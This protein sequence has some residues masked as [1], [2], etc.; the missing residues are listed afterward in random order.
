MKIPVASLDEGENSI[1]ADA[2]AE[3]LGFGDD[4][5]ARG[6][7]HIELSLYRQGKEVQVRGRANG[8]LAEECGRCLGPVDLAISAQFMV[9]ADEARRV[10][11]E[12]A[13]EDDPE[14]FFIRYHRGTIELAP[15]IREAILLERPLRVLCMPEC[16]GLCP[17]CGV[18]LNLEPC[19]CGSDPTRGAPPAQDR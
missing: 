8:V 4:L 13:P 18:N 3:E 9:L 15:T 16:R 11:D 19:R 10:P 1:E 2:S 7:F 5:S 14:I 17:G 12:T 6:P